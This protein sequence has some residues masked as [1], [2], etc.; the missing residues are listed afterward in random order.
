MPTPES[1]PRPGASEPG[2]GWHDANLRIG[3]AERTE[4]ADRLAKH[5]SDGRLDEAEFADRL[6]RAMRAKTMPDLTGLL[7]DL[8]ESGPVPPLPEPAGGRRHQRKLLRLQ[9]E[10]ERERLKHERRTY[11]RAERHEQLRLLSWF[12]L[13]AGLVVAVAIFV[14]ALGHAIGAWLLIGFIAFLWLRHRAAA[15]H[16]DDAA[17]EHRD[18]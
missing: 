11:R 14:H 18:D 16:R 4:V 13:L 10:R 8:P 12:P 7:A 1:S 15:D 17:G 3:D 5:F 2:R 6:D 9:L